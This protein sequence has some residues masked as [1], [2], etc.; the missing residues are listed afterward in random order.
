MLTIAVYHQETSM[1]DQPF[2]A[3]ARRLG[4][5]IARLMSSASAG[6]FA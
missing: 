4:I 5:L 1:R 6:G 3:T 2:N